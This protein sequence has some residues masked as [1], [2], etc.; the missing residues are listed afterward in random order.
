MLSIYAELSNHV[1]AIREIV[2]VSM[3][4]TVLTIE[5]FKIVPTVTNLICICLLC[6]G[7]M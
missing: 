5:R 3:Q 4:G 7:E 1:L 6:D 2:A